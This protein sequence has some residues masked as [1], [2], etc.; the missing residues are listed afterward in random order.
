MSK[1]SKPISI[2]GLGS[3]Q[4]TFAPM[5][6][7]KDTRISLDVLDAGCPAQPTPD[8]YLAPA[9]LA[10]LMEACAARLRECGYTVKLELEKPK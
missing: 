9:G 6:S 7:V 2:Q 4:L 3:T 8:I 10:E 5:W 1:R